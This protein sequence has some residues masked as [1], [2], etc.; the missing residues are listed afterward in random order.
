LLNQLKMYAR[1]ARGLPGFLRHTITLSDAEQIV[2]RGLDNREANFLR[3]IERGVFGHARSPYRWLMGNAGCEM[4]DLRRMV[5]SDGVEAALLSLRRAGVYITFEE[6]KGRSPVVRNGKSLE[7]CAGDFTNPFLSTSYQA[8]TG[9]TTGAGTRVGQDLDH[10]AVQSAHI[11]LHNHAQ[12]TLDVPQAIWRGVLPDGSG[13]NSVL[14]S[15]H[16]G[17]VPAKWF[18]VNRPGDRRVPLRFGLATYGTVLIGRAMGVPIP[19]PD[20]VHIDRAVVVARWARETVERHGACLINVAVSRALRVCVAA[21]E[22]GI[23]LT[24][25]VFVIAGE[26]PTPAKVAGIRASGAR[27]YTTYGFAEGG[28]LAIGCANPVS[29]NDLHLLRDA[30]AVYTYERRLP[31]FDI[32]VDALNIT[33]L[34]LTTPQILLNVEVDDCGTVEERSCGCPLERLGYNLHVRDIHSYGK[35]TG[36]GVTLIGS[37][38]TDLLERVLPARFGGSPLDYQLMEEEDKNGFTR[39]SLLVS[40]RIE[41]IRDQEVIETVL[42]RLH[43]SSLMADSARSVWAQAGTL[44]VKRMEP[45]WTGRGKLMPLYLTKRGGQPPGG[46]SSTENAS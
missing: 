33:S 13:I 30:F 36:E 45:V 42:E 18:S 20:V 24:G 32:T 14:R 29:D 7:V 3:L 26:P 44:R 11:M 41:G 22:A 28:R 46:T 6:F 19:W 37:E 4:G 17:R 35:L 15:S 10:L 2:R 23:D 27:C 8:E 16:H 39:L 38:M 43:S 34:L 21:R 40:P 31:G 5:R 12:G 1:F 25:A 9:G